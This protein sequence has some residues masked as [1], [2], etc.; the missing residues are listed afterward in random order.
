MPKKV[1]LEIDGVKYVA[2]RAD[3]TPETEPA[4]LHQSGGAPPIDKEIAPMETRDRSEPAEQ[5]PKRRIKYINPAFVN[6]PLLAGCERIPFLI[7]L[8]TVI[9]IT[10]VLF[11]INPVGMLCGVGLFF[12]GR[13]VLRR[14][15]AYDPY[16]FAMWWEAR[17]YPRRMPEVEVCPTVGDCAFIGYDEPPTW[18]QVLWA[19]SVVIGYG[20]AILAAIG[21][22]GLVIWLFFFV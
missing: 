14:Y 20:L 18:R 13:Y 16:F 2:K 3:D 5:T 12:L 22:V 7:M 8:G 11:G 10:V 9:F 17:Q 1:H 4:D 21:S 19:W 6:P 15:A